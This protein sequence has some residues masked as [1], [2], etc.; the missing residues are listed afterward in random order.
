MDSQRAWR[1]AKRI[2]GVAA[3]LALGVAGAIFFFRPV[4]V[5]VTSAV[6][7]DIALAIQGVG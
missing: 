6:R 1:W 5:A 7:R 2:I 3:L 4:Q